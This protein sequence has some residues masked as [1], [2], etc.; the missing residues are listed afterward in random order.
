MDNNTSLIIIFAIAFGWIP[1][2]ISFLLVI[3]GL[4]VYRDFKSK[5]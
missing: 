4:E 2:S 3:I 5:K 1:V